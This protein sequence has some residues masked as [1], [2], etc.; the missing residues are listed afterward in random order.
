MRFVQL[1]EKSTFLFMR[2]HG[3]DPQAQ[4]NSLSETI[5]AG[6]GEMGE[7]IRRKDWSN[8]PLGP[9]ENWSQ[10]LR[11]IVSIMLASRFAQ[12]IFW[13]EDYIQLY[14]DAVI[15][16]YGATHPKA[17]G[18]PARETWAEIWHDQVKPVFES[19]RTTGEA[20][21]AADQLFHPARFGYLEETYFTLCYSPVRDETGKVS[22]MLCT[23]TETTGQVI[24]QRRLSM[25]REL[26][27]A[28]NRAKTCT[29]AC[30]AAADVI[31]PYDIPFALFYRVNEQGNLA[32]RVA[33]SGLSTD[34]AAAPRE[35]DLT[36]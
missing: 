31:D 1:A 6:G 18:Q 30:L 4:S 28:G 17:L 2:R 9:V 34:S 12:S 23:S 3:N 5:F 10:S 20:F 33:L 22:G 14:N 11:A 19:V 7:L 25:L 13:G 36:D 32:E 24:G 15:P 8:T 29:S 27:T 35:I 26:A 21:F 16:I